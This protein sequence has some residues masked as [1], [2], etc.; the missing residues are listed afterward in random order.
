MLTPDHPF[1]KVDPNAKIESDRSKKGPLGPIRRSNKD[2]KDFLNI[3]KG[4]SDAELEGKSKVAAKKGKFEDE[5]IASNASGTAVDQPSLSLFDLSAKGSKGDAELQSQTSP[6]PHVPAAP[7]SNEPASLANQQN[8]QNP[9][10]ATTGLFNLAAGASPQA[11][12]KLAVD[13]KGYLPG[14]DDPRAVAVKSKR[15]ENT[16]FVEEKPDLASVAPAPPIRIHEQIAPIAKTETAKPAGPDY[17]TIQQII[18]QIVDKIYL[19]KEN[20]RS[21]TTIVLKNPPLLEGVKVTIS[22]FESAR[23]QYNITFENLTQMAKDVLDFQA[24]RDALKLAL[25]NKGIVVQMITTTTTYDQPI[26]TAWH[27]GGQGQ[28]EDQGQGQGQQKQRD[29]EETT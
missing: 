21:D 19:V 25:D 14:A 24:N 17:K 29:E 20:G 7:V 22:S 4:E 16:Q 8:P 5:L 10:P 9:A 15:S 2:F 11:H 27:E 3:K 23:G 18:D 26:A 13:D 28:G 1:F 12:R 6:S